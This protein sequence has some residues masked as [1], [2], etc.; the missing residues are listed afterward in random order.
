MIRIGL[1]GCGWIVEKAH[2]PAFQK[3]SDSMITAIYDVNM[4][5]VKEIAEKYGFSVYLVVEDLLCADIDAVIIATPNDTHTYYTDLA[6]AYKKHILCEKPV[7]LLEQAYKN[8]LKTAEINHLILLPA[9][10]NRFREEIIKLVQIIQQGIIGEVEKVEAYWGRKAGIP[11]P[12]TWITNKKHAGGG[13]LIDIGSHL[14]DICLMLLNEEQIEKTDVGLEYRENHELESADWCNNRESKHMAVDIE[15]AASGR[16]RFKTGKYIKFRVSWSDD[17]VGDETRITVYGNNGFI[18]LKTLFGFSNAGI[19]KEI[20]LSVIGQEE[21]KYKF[22]LYNSASQAFER[23]AG[24]FLDGIQGK[25][26]KYLTP[27]DGINVRKTIEL[28]YKSS[29]SGTK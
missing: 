12:G 20:S 11:R 25:P 22:C 2:I 28:L 13:A 17:I 6:L 26:L 9:F 29:E 7:A 15:T 5:R 14:L 24:Y 19:H 21:K 3:R 16:I 8:S 1:I 4:D 23:L 27:E 18:Q 10:V